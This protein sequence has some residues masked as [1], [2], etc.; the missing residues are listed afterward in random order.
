MTGTA[1]G[2][3][4]NVVAEKFKVHLRE[5]SVAPFPKSGKSDVLVVSCWVNPSAI[6]KDEAIMHH[7]EKQKASQTIK[8]PKLMVSTRHATSQ[9][10][11]PEPKRARASRS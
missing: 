5:P 6:K 2:K 8:E 11:A 10:D 4:A 1:D 9:V 3:R 7:Q